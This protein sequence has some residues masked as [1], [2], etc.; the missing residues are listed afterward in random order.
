MFINF[1]KGFYFWK[2]YINFVKNLSFFLFTKVEKHNVAQYKSD[3]IYVNELMFEPI[4]AVDALFIAVFCTGVVSHWF[5][6]FIQSCTWYFYSCCLK[7]REVLYSDCVLRCRL[8]IN[9][10]QYLLYS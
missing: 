5:L 1:D 9:F 2:I 7:K 10:T 3:K 8:E 4:F 6:V